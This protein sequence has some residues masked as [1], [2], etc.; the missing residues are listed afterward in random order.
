MHWI[1]SGWDGWDRARFPLGEERKMERWTGFWCYITLNCK[2]HVSVTLSACS[3][4]CVRMQSC[5]PAL[6][7]RIGVL[8]CVLVTR[9]EVLLWVT[10]EQHNG[11]LYSQESRTLKGFTDSLKADACWGMITMKCTTECQYGYICNRIL[12]NRVLVRINIIF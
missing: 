1:S 10:G 11:S 3:H 5:T 4:A 9:A 8:V 12:D 7:T 6:F 2:P